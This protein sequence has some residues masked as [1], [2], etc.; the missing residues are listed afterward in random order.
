MFDEPRRHPVY[1]TLLGL[2][3]LGTVPL[4]FVERE[5]GSVLGIPIW[6]WSSGTFTV[7]LSALTSW[8]VLRYWRDD[9]E[10]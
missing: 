10:R 1:L 9:E 2:A 7:L 3:A 4:L 8:G 5:L 6:L